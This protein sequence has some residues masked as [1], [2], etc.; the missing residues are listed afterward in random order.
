[1][2]G[3]VCAWLIHALAFSLLIC[4]RQPAAVGQANVEGQWSTLSTT[5]PINPVHVAL[6]SNGKVLVVAGSGNCPPSQTGCPSGP[7]YGPSNGSGAL[8]L[9]P[10]TGQTISQ[11]SLSWDMFCNGMVLLEDG[12]PFIAGG[13]I[14]YDPFYGEPQAATFDPLANTFSNTPNMAHGRWYPT[15]VTLGDGR[16][17]TFSGLN[18]TGSTN[19]AVEFYSADSGWSAEYVAPWTPDLYPRLHLLPN[20]KVFY[21]GAQTTSK[22]FDPSTNTWNTNVA[23]TNYSG[24]RGYGTSVLLPLMPSNNFD[25]KVM[26]MGGGNPATNTTEIIDMGASTPAWQYGPNMSQARIEM[27]AVILPNGKVLALGGSVNDEDTASASLNADLYDPVSNTFSSAGA[28]AYPRLYHSVALL[29]PDATV[30]LA[31]GN[32]SRGSYV[33]QMEI[34]KPAYLFNPDGTLATRP[35]IT[36]VPNAIAYGNAFT[37]ATPDA[38]NISSVILVR[39]GTVTHAFGMDQREVGLSFTA[40]SGTLTVTAPPN[41]NIAPPGYYM[42]FIL[43][44]S[45]V[46]SVASFVQVT[47]TQPDFSVAATPS[48]QTVSRGKST[49]YTV[50]VTPSN[51]F[52][53]NVSFSLT[54]LP[55]G[56]T[57]S[58]SPRSVSGSGSSTLTVNTSSSTPTGTYILTITAASGTLTHSTQVKLSVAD[59]SISVSPGSQTVSRNSST[60][61]T[62]TVSALGPFSA[63]ATFS[64]SGLPAR[65]SASFSPTSVPGSG[66]SI[67]T[68]SAGPKARSGT[69]SLRVT[70]AGGGLTHSSNVILVI[71]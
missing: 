17:M 53:G 13:T 70:A 38:A 34:Y 36:S 67:L 30:W 65:T 54:G 15:L 11:F 12:R 66:G 14:Q 25:P 24:T 32:P 43:N 59:F 3:R 26:I 21:S 39:N 10:A 22:L 62:V 69:H 5:M 2:T 56:A 31:G 44:D 41:G 20:G 9:D 47:A 40:E 4:I 23:T 33:Q 37:V 64:V 19:T 49:S 28:N 45:A 55:S 18:E 8:L 16:V 60:K 58:F 1:M 27:N 6:L 46:P 63:T 48:S 52:T 7:P 61:Y 42:L 50:G 29:L 35:S 68:V 71:Q 57:A 51:G